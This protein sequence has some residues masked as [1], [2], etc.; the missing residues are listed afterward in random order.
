MFNS[1]GPSVLLL[2]TT[3]TPFLGVFLIYFYRNNEDKRSN[4]LIIIT[5][6]VFLQVIALSYLNSNLGVI[7]LRIAN[8]MDRGLY[9][10]ITR[11]DVIFA[12]LISGVWMLATIYAKKYMAG[13]TFQ[14]RFY[15]SWLITLGGTLGT[16]LS[17]DL[18]T[19]FIFF[20]IMSITSYILIVHNQDEEAM[21]AAK[22]YLFMAV[23]GGLAILLGLFLVNHYADTLIFSEIAQNLELTG[24]MGYVIGLAFLLGFG[25][26]AG[27]FPVHIWLPKAHPVAPTPAS[28]LLSGIMIKTGVYGI[29]ITFHYV[30]SPTIS[31]HHYLLEFFGQLIVVLGTITMLLGA[32]LAIFQSNMKAILAYSSV[33]QVGFILVGVGSAAY[34]GLA[35]SIGVESA[36]YHIISHA[37]F[38]SSL[39]MIVGYIYLQTHDLNIYHY[40]GLWKKMPITMVAFIIGMFGIIGMP[41]FNG[42]VSKNLLHEALHEAYYFHHLSLL[43]YAEVIFTFTSSLTVVYFSKLFYHLFLGKESDLTKKIKPEKFS[44]SGMLP[45]S[46]LAVLVFITGLIPDRLYTWFIKLNE[47]AF[48]FT[49]GPE[50]A[51]V[52]IFT[53]Y[54]IQSSLKAISIGLIIF[55]FLKFFSIYKIK[56][57]EWL[58]IEF[59][60]YKPAYNLLFSLSSIFLWLFDK[61]VNQLQLQAPGFLMKI[62]EGFL[63]VFDE[64]V[65]K[66]Q[67]RAPAFLMKISESFL[68]VFDEK[69][70]NTQEEAPRILIKVS[71]WISNKFDTEIEEVNIE[72]KRPVTEG[73]ELEM[74]DTSLIFFLIKKIYLQFARLNIILGPNRQQSSK[75]RLHKAKKQINNIDSFEDLTCYLYGGRYEGVFWDIKNLDFDLY[76]ALF[77]LLLLIFVL[78][79]VV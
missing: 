39:F 66:T 35:G 62:S 61:K 46:I 3:L 29:I 47:S 65:N 74:T 11:F 50:I 8:V 60:I 71:E 69:V 55:I 73:E 18:F 36:L 27:M 59:L 53:K 75:E 49:E 34:L 24:N 76:I 58:S 9:L 72:E 67:E 78:S 17:G 26:K 7:N 37:L 19:L 54:F 12:L 33:S 45:F 44:I 56:V 30:F 15:V 79:P 21:S 57:P 43:H 13:E 1:F 5:S 25:V 77:I 14:N 10:A 48:T 32:V 40:G 2:L 20:E 31:A 4:F 28:A 70:N 68:K 64:R 41:G 38:K 23:V 6:L 51:E 22:V 52:N 63:K 42:F 16:V